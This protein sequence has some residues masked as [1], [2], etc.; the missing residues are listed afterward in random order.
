MPTPLSLTTVS[1]E[2]VTENISKLHTVLSAINVRQVITCVLLVVI[3]VAGI[4]ILMRLLD[5][6]LENG[7]VEK[8]LHGFLRTGTRIVLI[9]IAILLVAGELGL[10]VTSLIA[11]LSVAGLAVSLAVQNALANLAG[12]IQLLISKPFKVGDYIDIGGISGTVQEINMIHTRLSTP[13]NKVIFV[14]NS[15]VSAARLTN[16]SANENRRVDLVFS[17]SYDAPAQQV[18]EVLRDMV[19]KHPLALQEPAPF[20]RLSAYKDSCI[21]Y[22]L[23]VWSHSANY[24]DLYFDLLEE[25]KIRFDA[26]GIEMTYPHVNVHID[27]K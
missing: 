16:F 22:T 5:R 6:L 9:F 13:D 12:G 24:W 17:A 2:E 10:D 18:L 20:I 7:R 23:R 3:C 14:P 25:A 15:D 4:K 26:A 19:E 1:T 8:T 21:E 11:L 27:N